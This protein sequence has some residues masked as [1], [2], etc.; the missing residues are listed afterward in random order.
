MCP[1]RISPMI[2]GGLNTWTHKVKDKIFI[3]K[4]LYNTL[5]CV[6]LR[7]GLREGLLVGNR[8]PKS[9]WERTEMQKVESKCP[10]AGSLITY[11]LSQATYHQPLAISNAAP[12]TPSLT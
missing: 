4:L 9:G 12:A 7:E 6:S 3:V 2:A 8:F 11:S 5:Y 1:A 10:F